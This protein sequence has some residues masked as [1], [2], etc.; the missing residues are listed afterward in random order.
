MKP[1]CSRSSQ[2]PPPLHWDP[3]AFTDIELSFVRWVNCGPFS[4]LSE[5]QSEICKR[6]L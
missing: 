6:Q 5:E 2:L 4:T 1:S 3:G